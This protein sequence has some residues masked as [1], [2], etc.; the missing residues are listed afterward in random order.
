MRDEMNWK[1]LF[2]WRE[3]Q[4]PHVRALYVGVYLLAVACLFLFWRSA[5]PAGILVA[6]I[7]AFIVVGITE[8]VHR[9]RARP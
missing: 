5:L 2:S 4:A 9:R 8:V 7:V 6:G 3:W 1:M